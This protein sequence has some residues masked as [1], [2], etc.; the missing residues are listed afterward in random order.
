MP[1]QSGSTQLWKSLAFAPLCKGAS[2]SAAVKDKPNKANN[3]S[4]CVMASTGQHPNT[5]Q[6]IARAAPTTRKG[7]VGKANHITKHTFHERTRKVPK[8]VL[9]GKCCTNLG[10]GHESRAGNSPD[11]SDNIGLCTA[12]PSSYKAASL[13]TSNSLLGGH[14]P[15]GKNARQAHHPTRAIMAACFFG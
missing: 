3:G 15:C 6:Q 2:Q 14:L 5:Q 4:A 7:K 1:T 9:T 12:T 11:A 10:S 8:P 13:A